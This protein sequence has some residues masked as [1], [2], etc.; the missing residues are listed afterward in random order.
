MSRPPIAYFITFTTY[1]TWLRGDE[2]GSVDKHVPG[3]MPPNPVVHRADEK[4]LKHPP[5]YFTEE[6]R[7]IVE[8]TIRE[9]CQYR[10]WTLHRVNVRTNHV[11]L[12]VTAPDLPD[13]VMGDCKAYVT[14]NLRK[15]NQ[16][17]KEITIWTENGSTRWIN[18]NTHFEHV[19]EYVDHQ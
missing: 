10:N 8:Q 7:N 14:R 11:H 5:I 12:V 2:R 1:G 19:C 16:F 13:K 6:Q 4:R 17:S 3:I 18:D 9:V 15:T